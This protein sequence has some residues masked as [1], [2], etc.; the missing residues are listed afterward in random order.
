MGMVVVLAACSGETDGG[1]DPGVTGDVGVEDVLGTDPGEADVPGADVCV[2]DCA[3]RDCG[4]DGCG[5]TC[6]ACE[7][8]VCREGGVCCMPECA[9]RDCG[10]DGCGG[11][12]GACE[13]GVCQEGGV[14]CMPDCT[15]RQ[16]GDDGCGGGCG[17]CLF[18]TVCEE[19]QC[20][21]PCPELAF[22][23][24]R[25]VA[26]WKPIHG[27]DDPRGE[28]FYQDVTSEEFPMSVLRLEIRQYKGYDGPQ[29][30]GVYPFEVESYMDCAICVSLFDACTTEEC[31]RRMLATSGTLE[32]TKMSGADGEFEGVLRDLRFQEAAIAT[33][34]K[35]T[36]LSGRPL[37][38]LPEYPV[39]AEEVRLAVPQPE[40]VTEGTGDLLDD[41][42]ADFELTNCLGETRRLHDLC[43]QTKAMWIVLVTMWCPACAEFLPM[44]EDIRADNAEDLELW[45]VIGEDK[46]GGTPDQ[47]EC[48]SYAETRGIDPSRVFFDPG[49]DTVMAK[50]Y[51]YGFQGIP[52]SIALD[53]DNMA[54]YWSDGAY[55]SLGSAL[56]Y[57]LK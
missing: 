31:A 12:C 35:T 10:D 4:D 39:G 46:Q 45:V 22:T 57:L 53:G 28:F 18:G 32:I 48:L 49:W 52:Y 41:N 27:P 30:P 6:G 42:I 43:G 24:A 16:C 14:C 37:A 8:G 23:S 26:S 5:G 3:G 21:L 47:A 15:D 11:T 38:C 33:D 9:G 7:G 40:C 34:W 2:P 19:G 55:G 17:D 44:A 13:G 20:I 50:I 54:F 29:G 51:P 56:S 1:A 25:T 36:L